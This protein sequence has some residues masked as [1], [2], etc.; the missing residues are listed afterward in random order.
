MSFLTALNLSSSGL[1]AQRLRMDVIASNLANISTTRTAGGG[2]YR[3]KSPVFQTTPVEEGFASTLQRFTS[4]LAG[5]RVVDVVED[6]S[7]PRRVYD[8]KHP[9]ADRSGNV[10]YPNINLVAEMVNMLSAT[11]SYEANV[12]AMRA[13]KD[14]TLKAM[15]IGR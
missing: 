9:D 5:V 8:P 1:S 4:P 7:P 12:T 15:E 3:R 11:R 10:A 2:P 14:M 13:T 6:T